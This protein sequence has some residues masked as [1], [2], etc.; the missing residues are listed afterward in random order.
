MKNSI[1]AFIQI[2]LRTAYLIIRLF[3]FLFR[4]KSYGVGV[5]V[6]HSGKVLIIR[7][8]YRTGYSLPGGNKKRRE[9]GRLT[10]VR[11]LSEEVGVLLN[12]DDLTHAGRFISTHEFKKDHVTLYEVEF[13]D[14][15][16]IIIDNREVIEAQFLTPKEAIGTDLHPI[17]RSYFKT[18]GYQV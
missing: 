4:P 3:W 18:K 2:L 1:D 15:P 6:W 17:A 7:N 10:A 9:T 16:A 8:S 12:P 13:K 14:R 11:E 5:A